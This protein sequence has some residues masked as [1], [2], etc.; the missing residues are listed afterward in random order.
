MGYDVVVVG[1]RCAGAPT[2]MLFARRGYR[3]L[4]VDRAAMPG[5]TLSTLYIQQPGVARLARW[6]VLDA[7]RAS[8]C[9]PL[10]HVVYELG[11]VRVEGCCSGVDGIR[12]AYAPRRYVLDGIL[13]A[14]AVAAGAELRRGHDLVDLVVAGDGRVT[15]VRLRTADGREVVEGA[16]LVVGAD[17]MRSTVAHLA[18]APKL[19]EHP[20]LTCAYYTLW[21][22]PSTCFELSEGP[23]GWV[24]AVP[25]ND[26]AVLVAAYHPQSRF[27]EV[28]RDARRA[29]LEAVRVNA[30]A[31]WA[32]IRDAEQVER[33]YGTGDQQNF[34]R[35]AHGDGWVLVGDAGHHKDSLTARGISDAFL[36]ADLLVDA[37]G[38]ALPD[39]PARA[40]ALAAFA[41]R[42]DALL[43]ENYRAT[44]M[45]ASTEARAERGALLRTV[46]SSPEW[47]QRYFDAVAGVVPLTA[48]Y[49]PDLLAAM[50]APAASVAS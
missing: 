24:S 29:Y 41:A 35:Q 20:R 39:P 42:R 26:G 45:V 11:E 40:G 27:D 13:A 43:T 9:P 17:G 25:T 12:E 15:G 47:T 22:G 46:A 34:F 18:A 16:T 48:L 23:T 10:D 38:D 14:A 49:T 37:L 44:L 1:A 6:G 19:V 3:V 36:Q 8:G 50:A 32:Q 7:V 33:L 31:L 21:K 2:A 5:D 4:L 28:R 30:P